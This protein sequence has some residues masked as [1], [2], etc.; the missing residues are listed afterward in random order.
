VIHLP[1]Q[2]PPHGPLRKRGR[3]NFYAK[4]YLLTCGF[5]END[6]IFRVLTSPKSP[7]RGDL[8]GLLYKNNG[9]KNAKNEIA[10][11]LF[12]ESSFR[13]ERKTISMKTSTR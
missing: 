2:N 13:N 11:W 3:K 8:E 10:S 7:L 1:S 12:S 9:N 6:Q 4:I 5:P